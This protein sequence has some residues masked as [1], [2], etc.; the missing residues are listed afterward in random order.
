MGMN[1]PINGRK[2]TQRSNR[3]ENQ[4]QQLKND[5]DMNDDQVIKVRGLLVERDRARQR[6]DGNEMSNE[7][8]DKRMQEILTPE[9]Y[10]KYNEL[11]LQKREDRKETKKE[12]KKENSKE[13]KKEPLPESEWDDVYR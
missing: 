3:L 1:I 7:E 10:T 8:F 12:T 5:L 6:G 4:V 11:K 9:Q 2:N 13:A